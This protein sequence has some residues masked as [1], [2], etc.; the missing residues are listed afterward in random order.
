MLRWAAS[1]SEQKVAIEV[2][3]GL[4]ASGRVEPDRYAGG[5]RARRIGVHAQGEHDIGIRGEPDR[6]E[7]HGLERFLGDLPQH[8][9]GEEPDLGPLA[10]LDPGR[11]RIAVR[12]DHCVHR[13]H[14]IGIGGA[15]GDHAEDRSTAVLYSNDRADPDGCSRAVQKWN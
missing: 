6:A 15:V 5:P 9:G 13:R 10:R 8:G 14:E 12:A 3:R 2:H 4:E 1:G 7:W 11:D